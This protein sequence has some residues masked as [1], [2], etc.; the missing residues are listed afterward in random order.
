MNFSVA[1]VGE[2][3]TMT[4]AN[5]LRRWDEGLL[6]NSRFWSYEGPQTFDRVRDFYPEGEPVLVLDARLTALRGYGCA[7]PCV[8]DFSHCL[9]AVTVDAFRVC[10]QTGSRL[11]GI[12][13]LNNPNFGRGYVSLDLKPISDRVWGMWNTADP[14]LSLTIPGAEAVERSILYYEKYGK[15]VRLNYIAAEVGHEGCDEQPHEFAAL[16]REAAET[17]AARY[18]QYV[19]VQAGHFRGQARV[20]VSDRTVKTNGTRRDQRE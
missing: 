15:L 17:L 12:N 18:P 9:R 1:V 16:P 5:F 11:W 20:K 13:A 4:A 2:H 7:S 3:K 19:K 10:E 6:L 8:S 14:D